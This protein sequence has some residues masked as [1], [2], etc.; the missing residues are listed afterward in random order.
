MRHGTTLRS[1]FPAI[2]LMLLLGSV[3][4]S[5]GIIAG[6]VAGWSF[7][8]RQSVPVILFIA[9][10]AMMLI[11]LMPALLFSIKLE[12]GQVRLM[13]L[14]RF[15]LSQYPAADFVE[16][17][18]NAKGASCNNLCPKIRFTNNR[19]INFHGPRDPS[20]LHQLDKDLQAARDAAAR[21]RA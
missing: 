2:Q 16:M 15:I 6:L 11:F 5:I 1:F 3:L 8:T 18:F 13:L 9:P 21:A 17:K 12:N 19:T 7:E 10:P 20:I 14:N 4:G